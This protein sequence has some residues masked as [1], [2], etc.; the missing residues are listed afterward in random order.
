[1]ET[2]YL[3]SEKPNNDTQMYNIIQLF[4]FIDVPGSPLKG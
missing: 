3:L 4:T 2:T 1:M